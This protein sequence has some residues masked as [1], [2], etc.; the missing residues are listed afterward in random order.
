[1]PRI[2][3]LALWA[4]GVLVRRV[5]QVTQ[6]VLWPPGEKPAPGLCF[7]LINLERQL[8]AALL[9]PE[10]Y[11]RA[12]VELAGASMPP[13]DLATYLENRLDLVPGILA[14][15]DELASHRYRLHMLW[16]LP[17]RWLTPVA[18]RTGL[19]QRFPDAAVIVIEDYPPGG[20]LVAL[21]NSLVSARIIAPGRSLLV[22]DDPVRA[23]ATV[24]LG[25][26]VGIFV[27][28]ERLRRDLGLWRILPDAA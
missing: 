5:A 25:L 27:D 4:S 22:D 17:R 21:L 19:A 1:M 9:S 8:S 3:H 7:G 15:V 11:C 14:V 26:D 13:A 6:E 20:S 12:A 10:A 16:D 18:Q 2:D 28:A 24:R 23:M